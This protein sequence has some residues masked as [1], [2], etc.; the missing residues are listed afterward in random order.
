[1]DFSLFTFRSIT[2]AQRAET[3]LKQGHIRCSL[4]R[5]PKWMEQQGCGYSLRLRAMDAPTAA[6]IL[7]SNK[8]P[9]RKVYLLG[10]NGTAQEQSL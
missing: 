10:D 3:V 5:T 4:E 8:I 1:M 9:Y 6:G 7:R 2:P